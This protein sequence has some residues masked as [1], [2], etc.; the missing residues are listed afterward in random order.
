[1]RQI[2]QWMARVGVAA[3]LAAPVLSGAQ[4]APGCGANGVPCPLPEPGSWPLAALALGLVAVVGYI[5]RK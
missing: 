2:P 4:T 5:R 3:L 1:M